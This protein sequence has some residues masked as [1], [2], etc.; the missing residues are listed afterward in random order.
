MLLHGVAKQEKVDK[1]TPLIT[2]PSC[3][4]DNYE[5]WEGAILLIYF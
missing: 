3:S 4:K 1:Q 2:G 5:H